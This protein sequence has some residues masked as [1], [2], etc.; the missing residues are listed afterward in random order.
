MGRR[1]AGTLV[2]SVE[3]R[4]YSTGELAELTGLAVEAVRELAQAGLL[5]AATRSEPRFTAA[6][7]AAARRAQRLAR[8]FELNEAG[9]VL[10]MALVERI[11]DLERELRRLACGLPP[12]E[13]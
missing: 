12:D 10:A 2:L 8:G 1:I 13:A 3:E 4:R 7:L 5:P 11:D 9:L 6:G